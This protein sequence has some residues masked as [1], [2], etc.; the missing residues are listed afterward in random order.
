MHLVINVQLVTRLATPQPQIIKTGLDGLSHF[1]FIPLAHC[2]VK[3]KGF[4][5]AKKNVHT[6]VQQGLD[7]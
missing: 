2:C 4:K 7:A 1:I 6:F 5:L 3:R